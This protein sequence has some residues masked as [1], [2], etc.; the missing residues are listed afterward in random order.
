MNRPPRLVLTVC[1]LLVVQ[2]LGMAQE[3]WNKLKPNS[4]AQHGAY[5]SVQLSRLLAG[6]YDD[7]EKEMGSPTL[8]DAGAIGLTADRSFSS[9]FRIEDWDVQPDWTAYLKA[10]DAWHAAFPKSPGSLLAKSTAMIGYAWE[11]RGN[12]VSGTV[13][14]NGWKL[15]GERLM[16]GFKTLEEARKLGGDKEPVYWMNL[17]IYS[18]GLQAPPGK[19]KEVVEEALNRFPQNPSIYYAYCVA[20]LPRWGGA[21]GEWQ[22]W[23]SKQNKDARWEGKEMDPQLY[24]QIL[25]QVFGYMHNSDGPFF[26]NKSL[27]WEKAKLGLDQLCDKYPKSVYWKTA[28]A[29]L[30]WA[31]EDAKALTAAITALNSTYDSWAISPANLEKMLNSVRA[32]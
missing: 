18:R 25:W 6:K 13:T 17:L 28:R 8:A 5:A 20:I 21:E 29:C 19:T 1:V 7:L 3:K 30:A 14:E 4:R 31:A 16:E 10:L 15:F 27:S 12:G 24:A 32:K 26:A 22:E 9:A 11:A 2:C 23:I